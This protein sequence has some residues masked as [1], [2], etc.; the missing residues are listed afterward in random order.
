MALKI[1][2]S[3]KRVL[4]LANSAEAPAFQGILSQ[5]SVEVVLISDEK[6]MF[7]RSKELSANVVVIDT[8]FW[9]DGK[10]DLSALSELIQN[11]GMKCLLVSSPNDFVDLD[12]AWQ[13]G[14][15]DC[16]L[17]PLNT[18][19][20]I[21]HLNTALYG[22][23]RITCLGGGTG[24]FTI[25]LGL[26]KLP[27]VLLSS[28]VSMSDSGGSSG[29]LRSSFGI[30]PPGDVRRSLVALSDAPELMNRVIQYRFDRGTDFENH[31][32]GNLFLTVLAQISGSM[33]EAVRALGDIL[34]IQGIVLPA[35]TTPSDLVARF[36]NGT[37]VHGESKIDLC[38]GRDPY[39]RIVD[40]WHDPK[41]EVNPE[42]YIS[43]MFSD[44]VILGPGDLYT[45]VASNLCL[46]GI[47]E[48]IQ[49]THAKKIYICNVMTKPGETTA[50]TAAD[51]VREIV[52]YLGGDYLDYV[53][54]STTQFSDAAVSEYAK[55]GQVLV[56][57]QDAQEIQ[58][59][60]KAKVILGDLASEQELVRHD[61]NKV[62]NEIEKLL[63]QKP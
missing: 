52:K 42:A 7:Q 35:T 60:T 29:R 9:R 27:N 28:V 5:L 31:S 45:S 34:N 1:Q 33:S 30:L 2:N 62:K 8:S 32:F 14:A 13:S 11:R 44:L 18:R 49:K 24:L 50:Y 59:I 22:K 47:R 38:E 26:K 19:E 54:L 10:I 25:L 21:I 55:L 57:A 36:E 41:P 3:K 4:L 58:K 43:I 53:F 37:I 40:L 17:K 39:L 23:R 16:V 63:T 46:P 12:R 48:A 6:E 15:Y 56:L 61:S 20:F 51:H